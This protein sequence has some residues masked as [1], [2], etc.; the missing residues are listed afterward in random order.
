MC[1][2]TTTPFSG[3]T[4]LT[5]DLGAVIAGSVEAAAVAAALAAPGRWPRLKK[6]DLRLSYCSSQ[7]E[8]VLDTCLQQLASSLGNLQALQELVVQ[9]PPGPGALAGLGAA[10][11]LTSLQLGVRYDGNKEPCTGDLAPL[12]GLTRLKHLALRRPTPATCSSSSSSSLPTSLHT[13]ECRLEEPG[14]TQWMQQLEACPGLRS[15]TLHHHVTY[16]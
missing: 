11:Q 10:T 8:D 14:V 4:R 1:A 13:L 3:C 9:P 7:Q 15:L 12:S 5:L 6:L 2:A 16:E